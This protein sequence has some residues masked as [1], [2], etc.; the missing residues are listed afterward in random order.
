VRGLWTNPAARVFYAV[1]EAPSAHVVTALVGE[2]ELSH[3]NTV[4]VQPV[5]EL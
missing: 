2:P 3:W 1:A 5:S 4:A